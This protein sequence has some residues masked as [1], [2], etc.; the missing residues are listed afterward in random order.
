MD[1][2]KRLVLN[3]GFENVTTARNECITYLEAHP[4]L[5]DRLVTSVRAYKHI[6]D[7]IPETLSK[8]FSGHIFPYNESEIELETSIHLATSCF[9][10]PAM[11]SLRNCLELGLVYLYY[12]RND[13]S[14]RIIKSWLASEEGTPFKRHIVAG[15]VKIP[16]LDQLNASIG[17]LSQIDDIYGRLS[18]YLHTAGYRNSATFLNN[19]NVTRFKEQ[20]LHEYIDNV[21]ACVSVLVTLFLCKYPIGLHYTPVDDKFG[22]DG[23][24]GTFL[25]PYQVAQIKEVIPP[26]ILSVLEPLCLNDDSAIAVARWVNEQ[27]DIT[28]EELAKQVDRVDK[29]EIRRR[30]YRTWYERIGRSESSTDPELSEFFNQKHAKLEAWARDNDLYEQGTETDSDNGVQ[31]P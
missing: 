15:L 8:F 7:L 30:G 2:I 17:I 18:D 16:I 20:S 12:D 29:E 9:Y 23:P 31:A 27:P 5:M 21:S 24:V 11:I 6:Q 4:V 26:N 28:E 22:L 10:K 25:N 1:T 14:E 3:N 19:S 13:D